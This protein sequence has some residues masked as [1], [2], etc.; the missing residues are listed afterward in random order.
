MVPVRV[1]ARRARQR[2]TGGS[3]VSGEKLEALHVLMP[4]YLVLDIV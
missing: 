1:L 2:G 3:G 4:T